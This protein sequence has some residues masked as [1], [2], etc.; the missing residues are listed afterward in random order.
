[1]LCFPGRVS[2]VALLTHPPAFAACCC[3]LPPATACRCP[4]LPG[5]C[6]P[7]RRPSVNMSSAVL[8]ASHASSNGPSRWYTDR[9]LVAPSHFAS[10]WVVAPRSR[11]AGSSRARMGAAH[12]HARGAPGIG[13]AGVALAAR[14]A[15]W[16][17]DAAGAAYRSPCYL[18]RD[19]MLLRP[20]ATLLSRWL[21]VRQRTHRPPRDGSFELRTALCMAGAKAMLAHGMAD[22]IGARAAGGA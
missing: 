11:C 12:G 14:R 4:A 9:R 17:S 22:A 21:C 10:S 5:R 6:L 15:G 3:L 2:R 1:M 20:H 19:A 7:V 13:E 8:A 18:A 16:Q